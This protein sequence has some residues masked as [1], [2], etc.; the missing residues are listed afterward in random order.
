MQPSLLAIG[1]AAVDP[2]ALSPLSSIRETQQRERVD[3]A[4]HRDSDQ[5]FEMWSQGNESGGR[6]AN[7]GPPHRRGFRSGQEGKDDREQ[8][9]GFVFR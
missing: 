8:I 6:R 1:G 4:T 9:R 2:S 5:R 3:T 7:P